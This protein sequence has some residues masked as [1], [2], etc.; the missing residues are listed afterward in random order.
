MIAGLC[1][2]QATAPFD[3]EVIDVDN[4]AT[5]ESRYGEFVPVLAV[6]DTELCHYRL[7]VIK[8]NEYLSKIR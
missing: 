8:V 7:D 5:L 3:F 2:L 6:G 4:D 1:A